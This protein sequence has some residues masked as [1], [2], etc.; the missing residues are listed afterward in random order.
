MYCTNCGTEVHAQ[1]VACPKCGTALATKA[2][3]INTAALQGFNAAI[4]FANRA[5]L[6]AAI[7]L[8]GCFL[9]WVK[10]SGYVN[11]SMNCFGLSKAADMAPGT[12]LVSELLYLFCWPT[13]LLIS[14]RPS[15]STRSTSP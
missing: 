8:L 15:P 2:P 12:V 6:L 7:A 11:Q 4:F 10:I 1:A 13:S 14:C 3:A 9:P 5:H